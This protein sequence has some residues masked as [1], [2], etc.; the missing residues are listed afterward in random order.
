MAGR[1]IFDAARFSPQRIPCLAIPASSGTIQPFV[2][3]GALQLHGRFRKA[4]AKSQQLMT[5][6]A[7]KNPHLNMEAPCTQLRPAIDAE[8]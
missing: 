3:D 1:A 2:Q 8:V 7:D 6:G 4:R 5:G